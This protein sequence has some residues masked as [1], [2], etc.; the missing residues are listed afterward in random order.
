MFEQ[1]ERKLD[2]EFKRMVSRDWE[3]RVRDEVRWCCES[4]QNIDAF[5]RGF[6]TSLKSYRIDSAH[7]ISD[8]YKAIA[9]DHE[10]AHV[11]WINLSGFSKDKLVAVV[12]LRK[13]V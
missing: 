2:F 7:H 6:N 1:R 11:M 13:N 3:I 12:K 5:V 4:A 8:A 9:I 10:T